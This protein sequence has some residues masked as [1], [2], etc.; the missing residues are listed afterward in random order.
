MSNVVWTGGGPSD[1]IHGLNWGQSLY[2]PDQAVA[3]QQGAN[4]IAAIN[5][6][7]PIDWAQAA[8]QA[9]AN[10][11]GYDTAVSTAN[12]GANAS[13]QNAQTA[14]EASKYGA[15]QAYQSSVYGANAQKQAALGVAAQNAAA[16][17]YGSTAA[18]QASEYGS[19][20]QQQA[21]EYGSDAQKSAAKYTADAN[22]NI[23]A[24]QTAFK[25]GVFNQLLPLYNQALSS[26]S[27]GHG[28]GGASVSGA[29]GQ[30]PYTDQQIQQNVNSQRAQADAAT[31]SQKLQA[32]RQLTSGGF[33]GNSPLL[34]SLTGQLDR[35]NLGNKLD[36]ERTTRNNAAVANSGASIQN[37]QI[38]EQGSAAAAQAN[39]S[40]YNAHLNYGS[41]LL[42]ALAGIA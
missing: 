41:Q 7:L 42:A 29:G 2:N 20:A 36:A 3:A 27:F 13:T 8:N 4:Q 28:G 35:A 16:S 22:Q 23:A 6:H 19:T 12:I 10:Q 1:G 37:A 39:A 30:L 17:E 5:A 31:A 25:Q 9:Q 11:L 18:Q 21:S 14:A 26:S 40:M 33:G 15:N 32:R 24:G 38:A 34:D